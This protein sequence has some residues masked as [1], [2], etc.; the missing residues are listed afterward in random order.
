M[1]NELIDQSELK[2]KLLSKKRW[3]EEEFDE[4]SRPSERWLNYQLAAHA[5]PFIKIGAKVFLDPVQT[6]A[7]MA[8]KNTVKAQ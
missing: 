2:K 1:Q 4:A 5:L 3:L 7:A 6:R 8:K